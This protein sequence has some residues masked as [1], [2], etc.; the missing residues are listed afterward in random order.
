MFVADAICAAVID[1]HVAAHPVHTPAPQSRPPPPSPAVAPQPAP[2]P[3]SRGRRGS[4]GKLDT[5]RDR[6]AK[7]RDATAAHMREK[8]REIAEMEVA[9]G[10]FSMEES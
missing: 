8:E 2:A 7:E 6:L 4:A 3:T 5:E 10:Q 9:I 1:K